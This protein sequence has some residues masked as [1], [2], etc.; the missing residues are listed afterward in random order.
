MELIT[1]RGP[2]MGYESYSSKWRTG[3]SG[4]F[5]IIG[6]CFIL[7]GAL[8]FTAGQREDLQQIYDRKVTTAGA[9][10]GWNLTQVGDVNGDGNIDYGMGSPGEDKAYVMLGPLSKNFNP[11]TQ[12]WVISGPSDSDFGWDIQGIGDFNDDDYDDIII[13]APGDDKAFIFEGSPGNP[14]SDHTDA[15][16][17]INGTGGEMF[18]HSVCGLNYDGETGWF[19]VVGAPLNIHFLEGIGNYQSGAVFMFNLTYLRGSGSRYMNTTNAN[20]TFTGS[21]EN[22]KFGHIVRNVGDLNYDFIDDLGMGDPFYSP[23]GYQ[24]KGAFYLQFGKNILAEPPQRLTSE[25]DSVLSG[26]N[27]SRFG[28]SAKGLEDIGG[29]FEDDL[30]VGAP[31]EGPGYAYLF[32]GV[33]G[34]FSSKDLAGTDTADNEFN[35]TNTGDLFGW[36]LDRTMIAGGNNVI[37]ISAPGYDNGTDAD[38]GAVYSFWGWAGQETAEN[39][40]SAYIG[41]T[42]GEMLGWSLCEAN[43]TIN[44]P[45]TVM[46]VMVSSPYYGSND[47][48]RLQIFKRNQLPT[49]SGVNVNFP[50]GSESTEFTIRMEYKDPDN[51]APLYVRVDFF[52]D[53]LGTNLAKTV[54]LSRV[55]S[56]TDPFSVGVTYQTTTTL[57]NSI[58]RQDPDEELYRRGYTRAVRGSI[59]VVYSG[60]IT[61]G[62]R[63]DGIIPSAPENLNVINYTTL[64]EEELI[65]G[66]FKISWEWPEDNDMT[67]SSK[68]EKVDSLEIRY[69]QGNTTITENNWDDAVSYRVLSGDAEILEPF[70]RQEMLIGAQDQN[71]KPF[72]YYSVAMRA[73]DEVENEGNISATLNAEAYWRRPEI[74][75]PCEDVIIEDYKG[76]DGMGDDGG[77]LLVRFTPPRLERPSDIE[78]YE[79]FIIPAGE[80]DVNLTDYQNIDWEPDLVIT[81]E[82]EEAFINTTKVIDSYHGGDLQDGEYYQV[83]VVPVNWLD[84][85]S[86]AVTWSDPEVKVKVINDNLPPIPIIRDV[87]AVSINGEESIRVTWTPTTLDRFTQYEI[88]GQAF[89]YDSIDNAVRI[90]TIDEIG[91]S[92]YVVDD[93]SGAE[94]SQNFLYSFT[95]LVKDHNDHMST[96]VEN[97]NT[98]KGVKYIDPD[99]NIPDQIK[100]V[101]MVDVPNDGGGALTLSWFRTFA[102]TFWQYNVYFS[103]K[104]ITDVTS[105]DPISV[106]SSQQ[107]TDL[108]ITEYDGDPLIDGMLYHAVVTI[109][110]YDLEEN[111]QVD[112]N[113]SASAEPVNQSDFEAPSIFPGNLRETGEITNTAFTVSW[114]P[115]TKDQVPDFDHYLVSVSGPRGAE[116]FVVEGGIDSTSLEIDR[117]T[118][119]T[120]YY[121]NISIVDDNGNIGPGSPSLDVTTSGADQ[122][123][124]VKK[125]TV[126]I[127]EDLYTLN[128]TDEPL[129]V[130]LDEFSIIY[131]T[132]EGEDDYTASSRLLYAWNITLPSGETVEKSSYTFDLD[133]TDTGTYTIRLVVTDQAGM[134]SEEYQVEI[135]AK[136]DTTDDE[137]PI[138]LI[139]IIV[140][141]AIV[142]AIV[143]VLFVVFSGSRSQKKQKLEEYEERRQDID[144]MEPI[145]TNLP[146]WT[147][148][149][150]STQVPIIEN[151]YCNSCYQS[152]EA[153][154]IDGIDDYLREHD[155]VLNE[156]KIDVPPGWQ[157]QDVAKVEAEKDLEERKKRALDALNEEY[158][159]WLKGTEYESELENLPEGS[160]EEPKEDRLHHEGAIVPG[161]MPPSA[162]AQPQQPQVQGGPIRPMVGGQPAGQVRPPNVPQQGAPGQ[163]PPIPQVG[164]PQQKPPE[165]PQE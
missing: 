54:D 103:D 113:N 127:G 56:D 75:G 14:Y 86:N 147:C 3:F 90:A 82:D 133:L 42:A 7:I 131:F 55:V 95:V 157:G 8:P 44:S 150:G 128:E 66:S 46:G 94:I 110:D 67:K 119:G 52:Y 89:S 62:P 1:S 116:Q 70:R 162:P 40:K 76:E 45:E 16:F 61:A 88:W 138:F 26:R 91:V 6:I 145:Y 115:V 85:H 74:P 141:A 4:K 33:N 58:T 53:N 112:A 101:S 152:H 146:T 48:G 121:V 72:L 37:S 32:F 81:E 11:S 24:D 69:I 124:T 31:Y 93:I 97:N 126:T 144:S 23:T 156:M 38:A 83:A 161:Q 129:V 79:V 18:G 165:K 60:A 117:L 109:V 151:A 21:E 25:L 80:Y 13:G 63:I 35:G 59:S 15:T 149:C 122:P 130:N 65:P 5:M 158:A 123:P 98:V 99:S 132:G 139:I 135:L 49:L 164:V 111:L 78:Y 28:W 100:G 142:L 114:D 159:Q 105:L 20:F 84:Q 36:S 68:S 50:G 10:T 96:I 41:E 30:I 137:T 155:L 57:P 160:E 51:D 107:K 73:Y 136:K 118:R 104:E 34:S 64:S 2:D 43:Y 140:I 29:S 27:Q 9:L 106:I 148:D 12:G 153:V 71:I 22:G 108:I 163:R 92:E 77:K 120:T 143:V 154:P 134:E 87:D 17:Q 47:A 19:A 102:Q 39:A 125:I